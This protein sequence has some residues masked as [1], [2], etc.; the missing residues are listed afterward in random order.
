VLLTNALAFSD[1]YASQNQEIGIQVYQQLSGE[2]FAAGERVTEDMKQLIRLNENNY[3]SSIEYP[4][5]LKQR[6][7][8]DMKSVVSKLKTAIIEAQV[9]NMMIASLSIRQGCN[10]S[11][12][13]F[14]I[15]ELGPL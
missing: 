9:T 10:D 12:N 11:L 3:S 15:D 14:I 2:L 13:K 5:T 1:S 4:D 7:E 8:R 6:F